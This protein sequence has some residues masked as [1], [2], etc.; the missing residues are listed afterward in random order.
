MKTIKANN[1]ACPIDG[2]KLTLNDKQFICVN[3]HS[4]DIAKQ[5]YV[6]LLPV[7][8]KR[9][10]DPGDSKEMV[11]ARANFLNTGVYEPIAKK[12]CEIALSF[13]VDARQLCFMDAGCGEGYYFD[14][15]YN[16]FKKIEGNNKLSFIGLD[17]SKNAI[18]ESAK[19]NKHITWVVG[20]NRQPPVSNNSV[21]LILCVFGFHSFNGFKKVL[22][23]NSNIILVEAGVDHLKELREIIYTEVK[24][25]APPSLSVAEEL[26]FKLIDTQVLN[27]KTGNINNQAIN[28]LLLMTP[29]FFRANKEGQETAMNL[30]ELNLTVD[31]I[32]RVL[33][34]N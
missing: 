15:A 17:I 29:H 33:N 24:K 7:Q 34:K 23:N 28:Q 32:F 5:G 2:E 1:L 25:T 4:F 26:G 11:I 3:G 12:L 20:T 30:Q 16:Y 13:V 31:V 14:Y 6:N 8:H 22:K 21:D 9:S 18:V 27:F 10:K 19:R